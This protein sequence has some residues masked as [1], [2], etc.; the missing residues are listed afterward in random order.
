MATINIPSPFRKFTA[1]KAEF[2]TEEKTV[3]G[4]L[5]HLSETYP[6]L[7]KNLFT[8]DGELLQFIRVYKGE[9]DINEING[10]KTAIDDN[11]ELTIIPA[12]AGG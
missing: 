9:K 3:Q 5:K 6:E 7:K 2:E 1:Q 8:P 12:I 10:L 11:D 4:L